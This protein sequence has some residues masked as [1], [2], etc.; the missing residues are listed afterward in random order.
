MA[1]AS[2]SLDGDDGAVHFDPKS[3]NPYFGYTEDDG[4][5]H[6]V[7]F[8]DSTTAFNS[9]KYAASRGVRGRALWYVG[10]EDP[11]IW[12]FFGRGKT[13][14]TKLPDISTRQIRLRDRLRG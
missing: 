11:T 13:T 2:E 7:W 6:V 9:M 5:R 1:T 4:K 10:S 3:R 14:A 12:S 8:L